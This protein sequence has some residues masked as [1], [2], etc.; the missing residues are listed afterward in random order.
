MGEHSAHLTSLPFGFRT[1]LGW[2]TC[3]L[4]SISML[5]HRQAIFESKG[6]ELFSSAECRIRA[7]KSQDTSSTT[8]W[9]PIHKPTKLSRIKLKLE[10]NSPSLWWVSIQLTWLHCRFAFALGL[11]DIHVCCCQFRC[12]GTGKWYSNRKE[13]NCLPL[14]NA[15]FELGSL[16]TPIRQQI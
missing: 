4:L 6:D 15:G 9:M 7:W 3:L 2:Y 10:L 13:T 5:W 14:L 11:G 16:K 8:N 1:C 12:S